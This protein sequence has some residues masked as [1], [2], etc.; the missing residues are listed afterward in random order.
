MAFAGSGFYKGANWEVIPSGFRSW[1]RY[2]NWV[3][4]YFVGE[5]VEFTLKV[6][7]SEDIHLNKIPL[8]VRYSEPE[9]I[10]PLQDQKKLSDSDNSIVQHGAMISGGK[11]IEYW[12][13][14]PRKVK[15]QLIFNA[16]GN[17]NDEVILKILLGFF[18]A[19]VGFIFGRIAR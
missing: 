5:R 6:I 17:N 16:T 15:S 4:P 11:T 8:Y 19:F 12:I 2:G 10:A 18:L 14:D 13:G 1:C 9:Y 7:P 3:F